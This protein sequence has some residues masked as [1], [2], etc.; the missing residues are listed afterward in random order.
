MQ[1]LY[2]I[3]NLVILPTNIPNLQGTSLIPNEVRKKHWFNNL[4]LLIN[5]SKFIYS[6]QLIITLLKI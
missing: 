5:K 2:K 4:L 3:P 1:S 6:E